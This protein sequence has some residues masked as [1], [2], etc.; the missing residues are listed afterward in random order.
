M[1]K[2]ESYWNHFVGKWW[3]DYDNEIL[4]VLRLISLPKTSLDNSGAPVYTA[5]T[6]REVQLEKDIRNSFY[7]PNSIWHSNYDKYLFPYE[8]EQK[9]YRKVVKVVFSKN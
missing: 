6:Y 8:P 4:F 9:D 7:F 1:T 3:I 5:A 2:D